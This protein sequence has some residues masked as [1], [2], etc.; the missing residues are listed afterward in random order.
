MLRQHSASRSSGNQIRTSNQ[1]ILQSTAPETSL[2]TINNQISWA[3]GERQFRP[4]GFCFKKKNKKHLL[5]K[6]PLWRL[7]WG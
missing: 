3:G 5:K 2:A 6:L 1:V 4:Q 7:S